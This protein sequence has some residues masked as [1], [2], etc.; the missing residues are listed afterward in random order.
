MLSMIIFHTIILLQKNV[1]ARE[2]KL[3]SY[4]EPMWDKVECLLFLIDQDWF[5]FIPK[6][7]FY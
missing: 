2:V 7:D 4:L 3:H 5:I 1:T 6:F